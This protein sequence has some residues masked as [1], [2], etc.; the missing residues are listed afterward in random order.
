MNV[1]KFHLGKNN[2]FFR[3]TAGIRMRMANQYLQNSI[4]V[5]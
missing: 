4:R 1:L 5:V 3:Q 2:I